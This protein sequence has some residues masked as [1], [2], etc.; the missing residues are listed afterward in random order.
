[1]QTSGISST[2]QGVSR[3]WA[4]QETRQRA[5]RGRG[6][7]AAAAAGDRGG[8]WWPRGYRFGGLGGV[9]SRPP[10][11]QSGRLRSSRLW[12]QFQS[13]RGRGGMH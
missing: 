5:E 12:I 6:G 7:A 13:W 8:W 10:M 11:R 9:A 3:R 2:P 4:R 1:M